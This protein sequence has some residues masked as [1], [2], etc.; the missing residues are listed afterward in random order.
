[1]IL[2]SMWGFLWVLWFSWLKG[3]MECYME[4]QS[5]IESDIDVRHVAV[6][7]VNVEIY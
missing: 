2:L 1:M 5:D 7:K 3:K 4:D 6:A